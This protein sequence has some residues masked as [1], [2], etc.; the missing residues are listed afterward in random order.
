M[1][2][3]GK[4]CTRFLGGDKTGAALFMM[5]HSSVLEPGNNILMEYIKWSNFNHEKQGQFTDKTII[6]LHNEPIKS[7][8]AFR[9]GES[10]TKICD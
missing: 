10:V 4:I 9:M 7:I 8:G 2:F 3:G 6:S 1:K 5:E